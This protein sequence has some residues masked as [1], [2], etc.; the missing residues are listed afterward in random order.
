MNIIQTIS[1]WAIPVLFAITLHEVAHGWTARYFGDST[2]HMLGRLSINPIK[3]IDP[4]GT[5]LI[6]LLLVVSHAPFL[7][8]WAK[9][10]PV[11]MAQLRNP[12]RD[13]AIVAAAG[14]F[15]NLVMAIAWAML[16]K[17]STLLP[18]TM[19]GLAV[20]LFLMG[21]AGIIINLVLM[22]LN[23]LPLP[24]LDGGRVVTGLLPDH[25]ARSY[26]R[27]EPYGFFILIGLLV[28]GGLSLILGPP[29]SLFQN[30]IYQIFAL[31]S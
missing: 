9:P 15:S 17:I 21:Q 10:V 22:V 14:P 20:P 7:F 8:G 2:A 26:S 28:L 19:E 13:M 18:G 24:P 3:H 25:L 30:V 5:V 6:P 29:I 27:I 4:I 23:L 1:I 11:N 16:A 12:K 31:P